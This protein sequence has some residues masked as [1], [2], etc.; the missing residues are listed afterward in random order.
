MFFLQG[1]SNFKSLI[2]FKKNHNFYV[3]LKQSIVLFVIFAVASSHFLLDYQD[4][5]QSDQPKKNNER[6]TPLVCFFFL[7]RFNENKL[8]KIYFITESL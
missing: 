5:E 6:A 7:F 4:F 3:S 2:K 1:V 8:L